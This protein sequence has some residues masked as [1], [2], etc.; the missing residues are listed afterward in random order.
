[1]AFSKESRQYWETYVNDIEVAQH[2]VGTREFFEDLRTFRYDPSRMGYMLEEIRRLGQLHPGGR[3][4]EVGCG[5]GT[6]L[7]QLAA[8]GLKPIAIDMTLNGA[9]LAKQHLRT[10]GLEGQVVVCDAEKLCFANDSFD[11]V[12]SA[13]V[14]HHVDDT[15]G[16]IGEIHRVLSPGGTFVAIL[17]HKYSWLYFLSKAFRVNIEHTDAEAPIIKTY[18]KRQGRELLRQFKDVEVYLER[19]PRP[20]KSTRK[21]VKAFLFNRVFCRVFMILPQAWGKAIGWHLVLRGRK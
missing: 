15:E 10:F 1:M 8:I 19:P 17:Y 11:A 12:W 13:G 7:R 6:D 18:S 16:A 20:A 9:R 5:P 4:L 14:L 21:G 3:V 2:E